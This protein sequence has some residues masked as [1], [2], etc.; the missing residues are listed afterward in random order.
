MEEFKETMQLDSKEVM[1]YVLVSQYLETMK[2]MAE[3]GKSNTIFMDSAPDGISQ[4]QKRILG[5][6][7]ESV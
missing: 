1:N 2:E 6:M 5:A 3:G 7:N 4:I